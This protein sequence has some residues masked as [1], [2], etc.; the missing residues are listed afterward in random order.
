MLHPVGQGGQFAGGAG[1]LGV[2]FGQVEPHLRIAPVQDERT[3]GR[4]PGILFADQQDDVLAGAGIGA[5]IGATAFGLLYAGGF[6]VETDRCLKTLLLECLH[7]HRDELFCRGMEM[8]GEIGHPAHVPFY[9]SDWL[10]GI[11]T[12]TLQSHLSF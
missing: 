5:M 1:H 11:A 7:Q 8:Q 3:E 12:R 10:F 4:L 9:R 2:R 6:Q